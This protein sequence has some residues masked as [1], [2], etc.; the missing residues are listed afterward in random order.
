MGWS[1]WSFVWLADDTSG[2]R[3]FGDSRAA[4]IDERV[5]D[6]HSLKA[7]FASHLRIMLATHPGFCSMALP[8]PWLKVRRSG[9]A[10]P[11]AMR[12]KEIPGNAGERV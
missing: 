10:V 12:G 11:I 6:L 7:P 4:V 1:K 2:T 9:I 5:G 8:V 3:A